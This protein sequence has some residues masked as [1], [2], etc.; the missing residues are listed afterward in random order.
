MP[1]LYLTE[2]G[3]ILRKT[4]DRLIVEKDDAVLLDV[5]CH[6]IDSVLIFGNVQFTTQAVW[7]MFEHGIEMAILS[8]SGRLI[9]QI[10]SPATK[11]IELRLAQFKRHDDNGF[12]MSFSKNIIKGKIRNSVQFMRGFSYNHP[13]IPLSEEIAAMESIRQKVDRAAE[14]DGLNGLEGIAARHYFSG[15]SKMMLGAFGFDGRRKHPAPDPVNALL[16]LGYTLVFNEI[17]SLLDG[18]G[19][20]PYLGYYHKV[21]YGRASLASDLQEE[22][23]A[24]IVDRLTL[25]L[26]NNR[27]LTQGDFYK[28]PK[29][30]GMYLTREAMKRYFAEYEELM[31]NEFIHS[32]TKEKTTFRKCFRIQIEKLAACVQGENE[33]MPFLMDV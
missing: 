20:D 9:G 28:N 7:E 18:M 33:Y 21:D 8:R 4:G 16:S 6:K 30:E 13:E 15:L 32:D 19:F 29:G 5:E 3:S 25:R 27:M 12:K 11:N 24:P 2:Q 26:I 17:S 10:T 22:F 31:N 1:N 23:R 14:Q